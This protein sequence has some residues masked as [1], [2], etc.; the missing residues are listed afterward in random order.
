MI[1]TDIPLILLALEL[2]SK[3]NSAKVVLRKIVSSENLERKR[4]ISLYYHVFEIFRRLNV[5]DLYIKHSSSSF[6]LKK[7]NKKT[8]SLLR[9]ATFLLKFEKQDLVSV[10]E[11]LLP[12]YTKIDDFSLLNILELISNVN[13]D[14]VYENRVDLA[15]ELSVKYFTPTWIIRR[16]LRRWDESFVI[17]L[18]KSFLKSLPTYVRINTIKSNLNDVVKALNSEGVLFEQVE[19]VPNLLKI[20]KV[21]KPIPKLKPFKEG[22]LVIQ[23]KASAIVPLVLNPSSSDSILDMCASPGG[24]TSQVAAMIGDG[25][26]IEAIDIN[27]KRIEILRDRLFLLGVHSV[28]IK[29]MDARFLPQRASKLYDKILLDPPCSGS[30]TYSSRPEN[31]WRIKQRDLRWYINLQKDLLKAASQLIK[32]GGIIVYSTCSLL[33]EENHDVISN[34]LEQNKNFSLVPATPLVGSR[35]EELDGKAQELY[36]HLHDTEGFFIAK[37]RRDM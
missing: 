20:I 19:S 31:K 24:K 17:N 12:H 5:I 15:S 18:L 36:P 28:E 1:N 7:L 11:A 4:E 8:L 35:S 10:K 21:E 32:P 6:S 34:F 37:L 22:K 30:G 23:Q 2:V 14:K 29:H 9:L 27:D 16:F 25:T 26:K 3:G 33:K 13:E